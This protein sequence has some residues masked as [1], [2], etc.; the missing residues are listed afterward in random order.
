[1]NETKRPRLTDNICKTFPQRKAL[2]LSNRAGIP[3]IDAAAVAARNRTAPAHLSE[4]QCR[5]GTTSG[6]ACEVGHKA[7]PCKCSVERRSGRVPHALSANDDAHHLP[8][9][10]HIPIPYCHGERS[11]A[12]QES[13]R[14]AEFS[15]RVVDVDSSSCAGRE[16]A[17]G[18]HV[19]ERRP[20]HA[21]VATDGDEKG[22]LASIARLDALL[23]V[24]RGDF[25]PVSTSPGDEKSKEAGPFKDVHEKERKQSQS[26]TI[27]KPRVRKGTTKAAQTS[28][29]STTVPVTACVM[30]KVPAA[31]TVGRFQPGGYPVA[32]SCRTTIVDPAS[33]PPLVPRRLSPDYKMVSLD[34]PPNGGDGGGVCPDSR[35]TGSGVKEEFQVGWYETGPLCH[36]GRGHAAPVPCIDPGGAPPTTRHT[37][38]GGMRTRARTGPVERDPLGACHPAFEGAQV[39]IENERYASDAQAHVPRYT[40]V[41]REEHASK[42]SPRMPT[43][44]L[45]KYG[46]DR[47]SIRTHVEIDDFI[48]RDH[49]S[50]RYRRQ[51][52]A[53]NPSHRRLRQAGGGRFVNEP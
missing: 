11:G 10:D 6:P 36:V 34:C 14:R 44:H 50:N 12:A 3:Q 17:R 20:H 13:M 43:L 4:G 26:W 9:G 47:G 46:H 15:T 18:Q 28:S 39:T 21:E 16:D 42:V 37:H 27:A 7:D 31:G 29:A 53:A 33:L 23:H 40:V 49:R 24:E 22:L 51:C 32:S 35:T 8:V 48:D 38:D 19:L 1:M 45:E 2:P 25:E 41:T 5:G 52:A 30:T